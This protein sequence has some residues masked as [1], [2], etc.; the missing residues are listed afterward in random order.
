MEREGKKREE[1][2]SL[3]IGSLRKAAVQGDL[4]WGSVMLG[5]VAGMIHEIQPIKKVLDDMVSGSM[6]EI[7]R[8]TKHMTNS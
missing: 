1:I 2:D 4:Q 3:T 7:E 8:L 5:Q 6:V